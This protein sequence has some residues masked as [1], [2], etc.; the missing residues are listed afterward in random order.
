MKLKLYADTPARRVRQIVADG[1]F[2]VWVLLW[3]WLGIRLHDLIIPLGT[4]GEQLH[5][6]GESLAS[7]MTA[8][9]NWINELPLVGGSGSSAFER[10]SG[11]AQALADAGAGQQEVV[12]KLALFLPLIIG[13]LAVALLVAIWLPFRIRF[14]SRA[15]A[16]QRFMNDQGDI[17]LFALRALAR[18]PLKAL[19]AIDSDPAGAWRRHD[20]QVI[21]A[22]ARLELRDEGLHLPKVSD[23]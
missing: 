9:G 23:G 3:I 16:A 12:N 11:A 10:M 8:A 4:P 17:D 14:I 20:P 13:F 19:A 15:T 22:L 18:Q 5:S 1:W 2:V 6:A 21:R 7:N